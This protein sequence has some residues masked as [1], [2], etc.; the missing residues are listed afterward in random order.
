M[1][2]GPTKNAPNRR[3]QPRKSLQTYFICKLQELI[4]VRG[5]RLLSTARLAGWQPRHV[6]F[7]HPVWM[8]SSEADWQAGGR[9]RGTCTERWLERGDVAA[10]FLCCC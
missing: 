4:I 9:R 6:E 3:P 1:S 2:S 8:M 7:A 10:L 5:Q